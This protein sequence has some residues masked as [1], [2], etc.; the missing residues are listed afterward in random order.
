[1]QWFTCIVVDFGD[2][3]E[4]GALALVSLRKL[5]KAL[6]GC[7]LNAWGMQAEALAHA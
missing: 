4:R 3:P 7:L 6:S 5:G 2:S 1:M